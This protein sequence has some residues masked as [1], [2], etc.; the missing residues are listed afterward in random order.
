MK[1]LCLSLVVVSLLVSSG[2]GP[3]RR[4]G[5]IVVGSNKG[6]I[7]STKQ[8]PSAIYQSLYGVES[9]GP[10]GSTRNQTLLLTVVVVLPEEGRWI[11]TGGGSIRPWHQYVYHRRWMHFPLFIFAKPE[12]NGDISSSSERREFVFEYDGRRRSVRIAGKDYAVRT[13]ELIF[14][15][16]D[17][18]WEPHV[19]L[20]KETLE[21]MPVSSNIGDEIER[22]LENI[23]MSLDSE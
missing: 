23:F 16:F 2:C 12:S 6:G 9:D 5:D 15:Q 18:N 10:N 3:E 17:N 11:Y 8:I 4:K 22:Q 14:I 20:A 19:I 1:Y 21:P 13:G 7:V